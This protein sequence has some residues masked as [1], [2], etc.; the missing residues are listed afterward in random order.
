MAL[1]MGTEDLKQ[2]VEM[3]DTLDG[4][5]NVCDDGSE[6]HFWVPGD[7]TGIPPTPAEPAVEAAE[8]DC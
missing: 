4:P 1:G 7:M 3:I 6:E 2:L 8:K 5:V